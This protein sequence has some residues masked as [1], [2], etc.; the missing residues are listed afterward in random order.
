MPCTEVHVTVLHA[1]L[2][3]LC[4][5]GVLH[6]S[7]VSAYPVRLCVA[8]IKTDDVHKVTV[9]YIPMVLRKYEA[10]AT[11]ESSATNAEL[12]QR[13]LFL[14]FRRCMEASHTGCSIKLADS[15]AIL[16]SPRLLLYACDYQE[17]RNLLSLK[18]CGSKHDCTPC[19]DDSSS[20]AGRTGIKERRRDV[21]RTVTAQ[22]RGASIRAQSGNTA[23][24]KAIEKT[25]GVHCRV[26]D[27]AGWAGLG[28]GR[29]HLYQVTGF[30]RLHVSCL[31]CFF[32][33]PFLG[34]LGWT[35]MLCATA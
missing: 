29:K 28:S 24:V 17:E 3:S 33:L 8:N 34:C 13:S 4:S 1:K 35:G 22:L 26:H 9:G 18:Q 19:M 10:A 16:V 31:L 15:T 32:L 6:C 27:F 20:F 12:L 2:L 5:C 7:A 23:E 30:D 25:M 21:T 11:K 14:I